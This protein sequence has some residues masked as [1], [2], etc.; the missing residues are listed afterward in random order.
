MDTIPFLHELIL[1]Y[2]GLTFKVSNSNVLDLENLERRITS[3]DED[4]SFH[5]PYP[6]GID[7]QVLATAAS[8]GGA[9]TSAQ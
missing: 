2:V 8:L 9:E 5:G 7:L 4:D 3:L 6:L 1:Q